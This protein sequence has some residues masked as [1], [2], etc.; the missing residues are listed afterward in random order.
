MAAE[1]DLVPRL[2]SLSL[3]LD[4]A[5]LKKFLKMAGNCMMIRKN[6]AGCNTAKKASFETET[7]SSPATGG[8]HI[9]NLLT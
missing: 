2:L 8:R 9:L 1:H 6:K 3:C 4:I 5:L 7:Q